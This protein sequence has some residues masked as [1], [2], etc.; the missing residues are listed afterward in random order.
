MSYGYT[1][2]ENNNQMS[3]ASSMV[4]DLSLQTPNVEYSSTSI[5]KEILVRL[6]DLTGPA[7]F[8]PDI[9][10]SGGCRNRNCGDGACG[11]T[12][13]GGQRSGYG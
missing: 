5:K 9:S 12:E 6:T 2:L 4:A 8:S 1:E 3:L 7:H 13:D 11:Q 10:E